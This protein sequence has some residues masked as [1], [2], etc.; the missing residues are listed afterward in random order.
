MIICCALISYPK[1]PRFGKVCECTAKFTT[2]E[3]LTVC[4]RHLKYLK[5]DKLRI[6]KLSE[7]YK[8]KQ[9]NDIININEELLAKNPGKIPLKNIEGYI[10]DFVSVSAQDYDLLMQY[11]W[12]KKTSSNYAQGMFEGKNILMHHF[13]L[14][15]PEEDYVIDHKDGN[16]LNNI[17]ENLRFA[18]IA[19]NAQNRQKKEGTSS[20]YIGVTWIKK[21]NKWQSQATS[22]NLG[23]FNDEIEAAKQYDTYVLLKYGKHASTN[24]LVTFESIKDIDINS[25]IHKHPERDLPKNISVKKN[26]FEVDIKYKTHRFRSMTKTLPEALLKLELFEK[27]IEI[28]KQKEKEEHFNKPI[29]RNDTN[30]AILIIKNN[31]GEIIDEV[32]VSDDQWHYLT[33][34]VWSKTNRYYQARIDGKTILLH[35]YLTNAKKGEIADHINKNNDTVKNNTGENLRINDNSGNSH[36][37]IKKKNTSSQYIGVSYKKYRHKWEACINKNGKYYFIGH[38]EEEKEAALAYN[39]KA[40]ELYGEFA[41]LNIIL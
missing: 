39:L 25:I 41:N 4:K 28:I 5:S 18:T 14:G 34:Y 29:L 21:Q 26:N 7:E 38:F 12:S 27:E 40:I 17:R 20:Q 24:K 16:G 6:L 1:S 8:L 36:N 9:Q 33:Q 32:P 2:D 15:K 22:V 3:K 37:K 11:Y 19:Q 10:I 30:Q 13:I 23:S 31:K 35:R